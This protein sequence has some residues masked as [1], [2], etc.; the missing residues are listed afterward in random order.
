MT[1]YPSFAAIDLGSNSFHLVVAREVDGRLQILH[2]EKQR[3]YLAAGLNQNF[4][5]DD[6]AIERA[7]HVLA[8]FAATL[9]GFE[10]QNV[11]VA[12][13]YTLRNCSN[14]RT[15]LK[16]AKSV[17]PYKI[18]VISGQE[19]ARL[20]YQGVANYIHDENNRLVIDIGGGSTEI[21]IG[22]HQHHKLLTSRNI[23]CVT[24]SK[25]FFEDGKLS[26]KRFKKAIIHAEQNIEAITASY[27]KAGWQTCL[28]TSGTIKTLA[29]INE[30]LFTNKTLTLASLELI[31]AYFV[32]AQSL[33]N[34]N[35]K[36]LPEERKSSIAGGLAVLIGAFNQLNIEQMVY[37]DYALREGL[38]HELAQNAEFDIRTR[39]ITSF[40]EQ[41]AVDTLHAQNICHT[42]TRLFKAARVH[43][44]L[45]SLDLE[46]LR[47][48]VQLHEVG[49]AINSS[50]IHKH[51]AY[52]VSN[53]QLPGFTQE[54]QQLLGALIRFHRKKIKPSELNTLVELESQGQFAKLL[55]LL[56]LAILFHQKRQKSQVPDYTLSVTNSTVELSFDQSWF[57]QHS[58]F[59]AD[60]EQEQIYW[61]SLP[62]SLCINTYCAK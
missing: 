49:I 44:Q 2:K 1:T 19:E 27:S 32:Q 22:K 61:K 16:Q 24:M 3:V 33:A 14:L 62:L 12:A 42:I 10:K 43:W 57:E 25:L 60:L 41:Y 58:L 54:Q 53:S 9:K 26:E 39:T 20:I 18:N 37:C 59:A 56:R 4:D 34:I 6:A 23:G 15:F 40:A 38:L 8:Q 55:T 48:A 31:R 13:T 21:I 28:G 7:M 51:S 11:E 36:A 52:V 46:V 35:L 17:F 45:E 50:G 5:L 47:W 30:E 29:A